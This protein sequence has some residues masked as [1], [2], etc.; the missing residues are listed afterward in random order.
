MNTSSLGDEHIRIYTDVGHSHDSKSTGFGIRRVKH[1][2]G[3][4]HV[5][6]RISD[7][8]GS[9][10]ISEAELMVIYEAFRWFQ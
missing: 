6:L 4:E 8:L 2:H 5:L 1:E 10:T 7:G 3:R 9:A